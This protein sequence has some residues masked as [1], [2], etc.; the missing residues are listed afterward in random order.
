MA[1]RSTAYH[2]MVLT[3]GGKSKLGVEG[4]YSIDPTFRYA[5]EPS[6]SKHSLLGKIAKFSLHPL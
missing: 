4:C 2:Y 5:G 3:N 1:C 6:Y